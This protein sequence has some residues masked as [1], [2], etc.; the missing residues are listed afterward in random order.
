MFEE[1]VMNKDIIARKMKDM[2]FILVEECCLNRL[3]KWR[4]IT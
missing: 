4:H 3:D 1:L 2:I